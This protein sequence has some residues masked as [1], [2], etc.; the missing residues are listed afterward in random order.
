MFMAQYLINSFGLD[1]EKATVASN[2]LRG[3]LSRQQHDS[4]L[5]FLKS[6]GFDDASVKRLVHYF[7]KCLI[8]DVEKTLAPK[9]RAFKDV[10]ISLSDIVHLIRSNPNITKIKHERTVAS[11]K[12]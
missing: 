11:I 3:I 6:Y 2:L 12:F 8:L 10:D 4:I 7:T 1:Q 5:A 9:F